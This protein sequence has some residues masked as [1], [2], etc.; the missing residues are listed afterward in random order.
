MFYQYQ[1]LEAFRT[2]LRNVGFVS[3]AEGTTG[4]SEQES[5]LFQV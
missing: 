5:S 3:Q 2:K 1:T 4:E